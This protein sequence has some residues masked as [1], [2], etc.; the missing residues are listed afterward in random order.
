MLSE[1]TE[2]LKSYGPNVAGWVLL[3][4][5]VAW[6][7]GKGGTLALKNV[8][9]LLDAGEELRGRYRKSL[10]DC[11]VQIA[12]RDKMIRELRAE[13]ETARMTLRGIH[14][15]MLAVQAKMLTMQ[16]TYKRDMLLMEEEVHNLTRELKDAR[17]MRRRTD[18][19]PT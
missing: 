7:A 9:T 19:D 15:D 1:V 5:F 18:L 14:E 2:L 10:E 11:D 17:A 6:V 8:R 16:A 13:L 3:F 4:I 12:E